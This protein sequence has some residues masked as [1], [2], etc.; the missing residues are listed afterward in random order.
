LVAVGVADGVGVGVAVAVSVGDGV[1]VGVPVGR[2][3][4]EGVPVAVATVLVASDTVTVFAADAWLSVEASCAT[5]A[6][7]TRN[8]QQDNSELHL[9][10]H[11]FGVRICSNR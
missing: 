4:E 9:I 7:A 11:S 8:R 2:G 10:R 5:L 3:V 6:Q 1:E